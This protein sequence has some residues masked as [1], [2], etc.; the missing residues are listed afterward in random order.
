MGMYTDLELDVT[1]HKDD[2][3]LTLKNFIYEYNNIEF[4]YDNIE[5]YREDERK[6]FEKYKRI[7]PNFATDY[8]TSLVLCNLSYVEYNDKIK[9]ETVECS[10]KNYTDT[11]EKFFE[12]C[13]KPL[14]IIEGHMK[15]IYETDDE[16]KIF[17]DK[18]NK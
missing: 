10:I 16:Y 14:N 6:L 12:E 13:I 7:Y 3:S 15:S 9:F 4:D 11:Y 17:L 2:N 8:R 1:T 18:G 5:K